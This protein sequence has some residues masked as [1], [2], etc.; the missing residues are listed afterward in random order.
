M[1]LPAD[2]SKVENDDAKKIHMRHW[3][4]TL[5]GLDHSAGAGVTTA[6]IEVTCKECLE[7][8]MNP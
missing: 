5:C 2:F 1:N 4:I 3:Y 7:L 6:W 8:K